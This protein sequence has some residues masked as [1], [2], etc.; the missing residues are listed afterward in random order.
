MKAFTRNQCSS[1]S[2]IHEPMSLLSYNMKFLVS[3]SHHSASKTR[4][5]FMDF[6]RAPS[7]CVSCSCLGEIGSLFIVFIHF[8]STTVL[9]EGL[10]NSSHSH[11]NNLLCAD[12]TACQIGQVTRVLVGDFVDTINSRRSHNGGGSYCR[13]IQ[14]Y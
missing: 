7:I 8:I 13:I 6:L 14:H 12:R 1:H 2:A 9:T 3:R 11:R 10:W 5:A 4:F